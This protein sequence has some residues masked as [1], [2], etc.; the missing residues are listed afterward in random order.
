MITNREIANFANEWQ[1][2]HHVVEKDYVLGWLLAGIAGAPADAV[3]GFQGR[4]MSS[5]VLVRDVPVL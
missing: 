2:D 3:V 1:L 5:Q 4:D